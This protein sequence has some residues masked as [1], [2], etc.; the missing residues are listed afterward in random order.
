MDLL[1]KRE[2]QELAE[3]RNDWIQWMK[4]KLWRARRKEK[5]S[6]DENEQLLP[7]PRRRQHAAARRPHTAA[8]ARLGP[9]AA[10]L[11]GI[12]V[13]IIIIIA[14]VPKILGDLASSPE[15]QVS[16]I[17]AIRPKGDLF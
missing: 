3:E 4:M 13:V 12:F 11:C 14:Y 9:A 10:S 15:N 16:I 6:D 7:Q 17:L 8:L 2:R 1:T 5:V